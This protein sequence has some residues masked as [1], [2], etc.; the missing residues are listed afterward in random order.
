MDDLIRVSSPMI[1]FLSGTLKS[2]RMKTRWPLRSRS[3]IE[4]FGFIGHR[5]AEAFALL[6]S[7]KA[8][9][10]LGSAKAFA[11]LGSAKASALHRSA[12]AFALQATGPWLPACAAD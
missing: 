9:A 7:A 6:G 4:S 1:P 11:L 12:E 8:F 2:T 5:S 10:L 3:L